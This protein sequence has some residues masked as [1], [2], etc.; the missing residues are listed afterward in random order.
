MRWNFACPASASPADL[1]R[2]IRL[3]IVASCPGPLEDDG[4]LHEIKHDGH[5]LLAIVAGG[6]LKLIS[7]NGHDR[8]ALF[9][10]PIEGGQRCRPPRWRDRGAGRCRDDARFS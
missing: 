7:R 2:E 6:E 1:L 3:Q 8:T 10:A 5:R 4:W 9:C